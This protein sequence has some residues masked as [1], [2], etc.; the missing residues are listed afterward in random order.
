LQWLAEG[1]SVQPGLR[2]L[3]PEDL[4]SGVTVSSG[5]DH[6]GIGYVFEHKEFGEL[7]RIVMIKAGEQEML[8]QADLYIGQEQPESTL[9][10][11][12]RTIF[13]EVVATINAC[14]NS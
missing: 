3:R 9:A 2:Q 8:M 7:G 4:P 13:E 11:K 6:R 14:F 1:L 5:Y 12:K 10:K